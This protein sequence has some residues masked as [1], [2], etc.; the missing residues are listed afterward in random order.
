MYTWQSWRSMLPA[1]TG[2][3]DRSPPPPNT[4]SPSGR[5]SAAAAA[6]VSPPTFA[7]A[8]TISGRWAGST[9]KRRHRPR[10]QPGSR[11]GRVSHRKV[12]W[13]ESGPMVK[14][15]VARATR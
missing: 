3:S 10:C 4:G 2:T 8:G 1:P 12:T 14:R 15:P 9:P 11:P 13:A 6:A 5:P 7:V